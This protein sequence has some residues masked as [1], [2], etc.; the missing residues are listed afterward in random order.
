[1]PY[2]EIAAQYAAL[3]QVWFYFKLLDMLI[4]NSI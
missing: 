3:P 1:L 4:F 2:A